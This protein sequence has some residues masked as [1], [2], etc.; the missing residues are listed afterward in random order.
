MGTDTISIFKKRS[1]PSF[2][3]MKIILQV[4]LTALVFAVVL[5]DKDTKKDKDSGYDDHHG[6]DDDLYGFGPFGVGGY[7]GYGGRY[8]YGLG[9][10]ASLLGFGGNRYGVYGHRNYG[11]P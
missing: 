2:P 10:Y 9:P 7:G 8:G 5:A 3:K 1:R 6:Y 4:A 11:F